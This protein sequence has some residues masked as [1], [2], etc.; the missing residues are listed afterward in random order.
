MIVRIIVSTLVVVISYAGFLAANAPASWVVAQARP[1][2]SSARVALADAQGSAWDGSAE[3][4]L[5]GDHL[6]RLHWSTSPWA[7]IGGNLDADFSISGDRIDLSGSVASDGD[8]TRLTDVHAQAGIDFLAGL[9]GIPADLEGTLVANFEELVIQA[10]Q[11]IKAA[12]GKLVAHGVRIPALGVSLG[13]LTLKLDD[14]GNTVTGNLD[15][16]GGDIALTGTLTLLPT[17]SYTLQA[18]LKPRPGPKQNRIRD[19]LTAILGESDAAGR[20]RYSANGR[21]NL[22]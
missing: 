3:L 20:F 16:S 14:S 13:N 6:G 22:Q 21:I 17:G 1:Q 18:T 2:L 12:D 15:N 10:P 9:L 11:T 19:G 4:L 7:L 8:I 5:R